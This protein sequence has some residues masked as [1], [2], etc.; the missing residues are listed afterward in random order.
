MGLGTKI[1]GKNVRKKVR[2]KVRR[3]KTASELSAAKIERN[4]NK[5]DMDISAL[6]KEQVAKAKAYKKKTGGKTKSKD[7]GDISEVM[8]RKDRPS[9]DKIAQTSKERL[10]R[11]TGNITALLTKPGLKPLSMDKYRSLSTE[12]RTALG[13]KAK[14]DFDSKTITKEEY[15]TIIERIEEA[16]LMKNVRAMEQGRS[17]K[18]RGKL[19]PLPLPPTKLKVET[20][21]KKSTDMTKAELAEVLKEQESKARSRNKGGVIKSPGYAYGGMA[22]AKPRTGNMDY[23]MGGMFMKKGKK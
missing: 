10:D 12:Q 20:S 2:K 6:V 22:K 14:K 3:K 8:F 1:V 11:A 7:S 16:E 17:D 18:K 23:R 21:P 5:G 4:K 13:R 9:D 15:E 19:K